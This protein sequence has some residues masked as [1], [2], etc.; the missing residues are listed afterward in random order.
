M[1]KASFRKAEA[2][3]DQGSMRSTANFQWSKADIK[4]P[5]CWAS[6]L[7]FYMKEKLFLIQFYWF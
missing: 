3:N 4:W 1:E 5:K 6:S 7:G 2:I